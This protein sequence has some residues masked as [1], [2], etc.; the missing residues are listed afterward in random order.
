MSRSSLPKELLELQ[1]KARSAG[2]RAVLLS[3][4]RAD[5]IVIF[6]PPDGRLS[7]RG[8]FFPG[9]SGLMIPEKAGCRLLLAG[10]GVELN[11]IMCPG[12]AESGGVPHFRFEL[13]TWKP[14]NETG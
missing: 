3:P 1:R 9:K 10:S 13:E 5:G 2:V 14:F 6:D 7:V 11:V 12:R 4:C 8:S